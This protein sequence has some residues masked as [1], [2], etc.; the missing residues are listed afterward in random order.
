[1]A[2]ISRRTGRGATAGIVEVMAGD[3]P[4]GATAGAILARWDEEAS[5][6][7]QNASNSV[8]HAA[9]RMIRCLG[10]LVL[11]PFSSA[12][13]TAAGQDMFRQSPPAQGQ[14]AARER[15]TG[16]STAPGHL[17]H[18]LSGADLAWPQP[19]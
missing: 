17:G 14:P 7:R 4:A 1:M 6:P 19:A 13:Q 5:R 10:M 18:Y 11:S 15:S 8:D 12:S 3:I 16:C 9:R 2:G